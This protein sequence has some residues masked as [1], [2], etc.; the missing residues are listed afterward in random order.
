MVGKLTLRL[1]KGLLKLKT[2][3]NSS[4]I[5]PQNRA[6]DT[7]TPLSSAKVD[8]YYCR[9][10]DTHVFV[11]EC[12]DTIQAIPKFIYDYDERNLIK[13]EEIN[14]ETDL[15][16]PR[17]F[18]SL[19]SYRLLKALSKNGWATD[20]DRIVNLFDT[21]EIE[22]IDEKNPETR[23]VTIVAK[24]DFNQ[25]LSKIIKGT[26]IYDETPI[27]KALL[28]S[29]VGDTVEVPLP[30]G[31]QTFRIVGIE[32]LPSLDIEESRSLF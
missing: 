7:S 27:A 16:L 30:A 5:P 31:L 15:P 26:P 29:K 22:M 25:S 19:S 8:V 6:P 32:K 24:K 17:P 4:S 11:K 21:V 9:N 3:K 14:I 20:E 2:T 18:E 12:I 1:A 10:S 13:K 23:T 28:G